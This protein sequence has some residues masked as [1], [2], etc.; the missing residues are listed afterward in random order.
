MAFGNRIQTNFARGEISPDTRSRGDIDIFKASLL[1]CRNF[2]PKFQGPVGYAPG[3]TWIAAASVATGAILIPFVYRDTQ[4]Y[5][6]ELFV[7]ANSDLKIRI[8]NDDGVV[9]FSKGNVGWIQNDSGGESDS[10]LIGFPAGTGEDPSNLA[11][12]T[13][14]AGTVCT[15][16]FTGGA[17]EDIVKDVAHGL[18][19]GDEIYFSN[20]G[21]ALPAEIDGFKSF[22]VINKEDDYFQI[23]E[24]VGG[25]VFEFTDDGTVTSKY[26]QYTYVGEVTITVTGTFD[27]ADLANVRYAQSGAAMVIISEGKFCIQVWRSSTSETAWAINESSVITSS[28]INIENGATSIA[29]DGNGFAEYNVLLHT[30][31]VGDIAIV[32]NTDNDVDYDGAYKVTA[33]AD[34]NHFTTDQEFIGFT[35][36]G[37]GKNGIVRKGGTFHDFVFAFEEVTDFLTTAT[38]IPKEV[39]FNEGRLYFALDDKL[40]GSRSVVDGQDMYAN[41]NQSIAAIPTDAIEFTSSISS[42]K[43]DLFKWL[44]VS[45]K[46][47]YAGMENLIALIQ[48]NTI[49]D[50]IAGDSIRIVS[51]EDRGSSDVA[52][53]EDG[54]DIIFVDSTGKRVNSFKFDIASD[55]QRSQPLS[56]L[57]EHLF[58]ST[59]KRIV[60]QRGLPDIVYVLLDNGTLIGFIFSSVENITGWFILE[61][62]NGD[63]NKDISTLPISNGIDRFW[64]II[65]RP[66]GSG[67]TADQIEQVNINTQYLRIEDFYTNEDSKAEDLRKWKNATFEQQK[68]AVHMHSMLSLDVFATTLASGNYLHI[69]QSLNTSYISTDGTQANKI[70]GSSSPINGEEDNRLVIKATSEGLGE[71]IFIIDAYE[72]STGIGSITV[73]KTI[74]DYTFDAVEQSYIIPPGFW[75]ISFS[76]ITSSSLQRYFDSTGASIDI[77]LDGGFIS[78]KTIVLDGGNYSVDLG[79]QFGTVIYFGYKYMGI[80]ATLPIDLG[81]T[82]GTAFSKLKNI[83]K[84]TVDFLDTVAIKYG[85][86]PYNLSEQSFRKGDDLTD[87]PPPLFNGTKDLSMVNGGWGNKKSIFFIQDIP[88]PCTIAG[89]DISGEASDD[90]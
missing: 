83:D 31:V 86:D 27:I 78:G 29:D 38:D 1:L 54:K 89:I 7:D 6:L 20:S 14:D 79:T 34:A 64:Q 40:Y 18:S 57:D 73:D 52:P 71:G 53:I 32:K 11:L 58:K 75:G 9:L 87:R 12:A 76:S 23:S 15:F 3:S 26:H 90:I 24:T 77:V 35:A 68:H 65:A 49:D 5:H 13:S 2:I 47:F 85:V 8:L 60:F 69:N 81:G 84:V 50:P 42:D 66:D 61:D 36:A 25:S 37:V 70:T 22:Y 62:G 43:V 51:A 74:A 67:G 72:S 80:I 63:I 19:N 48:G 56:L 46:S 17:A 30:L 59:V 33:V 41:F 16:D 28:F 88:A 45:N 55:S 44:K 10:E 82:T 21:G 39:K 4:A